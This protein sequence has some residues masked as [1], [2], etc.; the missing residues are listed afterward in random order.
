[1]FASTLCTLCIA[2]SPSTLPLPA[3]A[4]IASSRS[5]TLRRPPFRSGLRFDPTLAFTSSGLCLQVTF[6][7]RFA[8]RQ[9]HVPSLPYAIPAGT[10]ALAVRVGM[11]W[12]SHTPFYWSIGAV[13]PVPLPRVFTSTY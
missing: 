11:P 4:I 7:A 12:L 13:A 5:T 3:P 6:G 2:F 1:M 9:Q 10:G 8:W